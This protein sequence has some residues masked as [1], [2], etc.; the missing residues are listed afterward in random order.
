ML[1]GLPAGGLMMGLVGAMTG[2]SFDL[3]REGVGSRLGTWAFGGRL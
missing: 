1:V 3:M 2:I